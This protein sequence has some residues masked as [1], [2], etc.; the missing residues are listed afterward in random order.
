MGGQLYLPTYFVFMLYTSVLV[1][2]LGLLIKKSLATLDNREDSPVSLL[3]L[4]GAVTYLSW[5]ISTNYYKHGLQRYPGPLLAK[6]TK[7]WHLLSVYRNE[8]HLSM[9]DIHRKYGPVVRIGPSALSISDPAYILQ[10]YGASTSFLK[11]G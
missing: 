2:L 6:F 10:I 8:H 4:T 11:V 1:S 9:I 5:K 3:V 7:L